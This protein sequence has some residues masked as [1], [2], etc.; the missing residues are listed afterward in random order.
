MTRARLLIGLEGEVHLFGDLITSDVESLDKSE[1]SIHCHARNQFVAI[2]D[3]KIQTAERL[4]VDPTQG[5]QCGRNAVEARGG[6]ALLER[7]PVTDLKAR[8]MRPS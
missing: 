4:W 8:K 2:L 6:E 7:S 1:L 5:P 3:E